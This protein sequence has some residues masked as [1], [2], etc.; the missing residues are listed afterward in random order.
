MVHSPNTILVVR[1]FPLCKSPHTGIKGNEGDLTAVSI[2]TPMK[3]PLA[4]LFQR[5][6]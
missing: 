3:S 4:P 2:A 6:E 5:G 1:G